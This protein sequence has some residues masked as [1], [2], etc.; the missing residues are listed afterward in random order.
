ML[1]QE[2][3]SAFELI[4]HKFTD[5]KLNYIAKVYPKEKNKCKLVVWINK[6]AK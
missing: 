1:G 2:V 4:D 3:L 5:H 6:V